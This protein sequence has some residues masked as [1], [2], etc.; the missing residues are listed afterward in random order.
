MKPKGR[1]DHFGVGELGLSSLFSFV[2]SMEK[3]DRIKGCIK[4]NTRG[5]VG[6]VLLWKGFTNKP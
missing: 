3:M 2:S 1:E 5:F 4:L 6:N